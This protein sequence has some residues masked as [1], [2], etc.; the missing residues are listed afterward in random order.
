MVGCLLSFWWVWVEEGDFYFSGLV[1][2]LSWCLYLCY[3]FGWFIWPSSAVRKDRPNCHSALS[4]RK[5]I[6][7][8]H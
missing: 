4:S 2:V 7:S 3:V 5:A 8:V 1:L 6:V